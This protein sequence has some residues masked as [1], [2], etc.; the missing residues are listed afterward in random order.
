MMRRLALLFLVLTLANLLAADAESKA[1]K[2]QGHVQIALLLDT[3]NSMDGLIDQAKTR[4][5]QV[6]NEIATARKR[7]LPPQLEVALY[8]YG[9]S[10][11]PADAGYIRQILPF[12]SDLD[13]ISEQLF[14][15]TTNGGDEYCG[16][17]INQALDQLEWRPGSGD[18]KA[19]FIA[20]NE[21]FDQGPANF[22]TVCGKAIAAGVVVNTIFCGS[23]NEGINTHW[24]EG[25]DLADGRFM[26]IDQQQVISHVQ[27]PQDGR[28]LALGQAL[29]DTFIP[30]GAEGRKAKQRQEEQDLM[31]ASVAE[32]VAVARTVTKAS[33]VYAK[34]PWDLSS[35]LSDKKVDIATIDDADLPEPMRGMDTAEKQA[36][37]QKMERK[38]TDLQQQ[39]TQLQEERKAWLEKQQREKA[40]GTLDQAMIAVV[41]EQMQKKQFQFPK[42]R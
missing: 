12:T 35:A 30:I 21:P 36:Y 34:E 41:R 8:E 26:V 40:T 31:A 19:V 16:L 28:I 10:S 9:K 24:K 37:V 25:A 32:E 13:A 5:W 6:V 3:S 17:V 33:P 27:A 18:F 11:I 23:Q 29:N 7:G 39:I 14:A 1:K 38:R 42:K 15:L 4:L 20:G 2:G 22:R